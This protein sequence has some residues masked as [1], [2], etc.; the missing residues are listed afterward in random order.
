MVYAPTQRAAGSIVIK[1]S[2]DRERNGMIEWLK[3]SKGDFFVSS[4]S[5]VGKKRIRNW[6]DRPASATG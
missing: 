6:T 3:E 1:R 5:T 4:V 2:R